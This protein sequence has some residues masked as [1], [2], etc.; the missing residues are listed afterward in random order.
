MLPDIGLLS[1]RPAASD[2]NTDAQGGG[3]VTSL[4]I[5]SQPASSTLA[6]TNM[7]FTA[8]LLKPQLLALSFNL[9]DNSLFRL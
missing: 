7:S 4:A 6:C 1:G 9:M 2:V 8:I 3:A 5:G